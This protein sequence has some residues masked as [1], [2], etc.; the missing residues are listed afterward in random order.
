M[1]VPTLSQLQYLVKF[2]TAVFLSLWDVETLV[3]VWIP[4]LPCYSWEY[5]TRHQKVDAEER[6]ENVAFH[7]W[8][9]N[10]RDQNA[11]YDNVA[12][13]TYSLKSRV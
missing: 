8:W 4:L 1:T 3:H 7:G 6:G 11:N 9:H 12:Q 13:A 5:Q 2:S 10:K